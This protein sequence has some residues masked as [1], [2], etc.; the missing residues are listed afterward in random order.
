VATEAR[1]KGAA[2][3]RLLTIEGAAEL[4]SFDPSVI[5]GWMERG[6]PYVASGTGRV[7]PRMKDRRIRSSDLWAWVERLTIR[8]AEPVTG[9]AASPA[10]G[11][12]SAWRARKGD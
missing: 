5:V 11:G 1:G 4:T 9:P 7:R 8:K 6:L 12:L 10:S 2:D 3:D